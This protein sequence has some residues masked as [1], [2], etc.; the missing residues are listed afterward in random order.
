[1]TLGTLMLLILTVYLVLIAYGAVRARRKF[2]GA[3]LR[4]VQL[5]LILLLPAAV[6][7]VLLLS[8][9]SVVVRQWGELFAAMPVLGLITLILADRIADKVDN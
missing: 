1:M 7:G 3:A 6:V 5:L 2:T 4:L 9:D 8:G